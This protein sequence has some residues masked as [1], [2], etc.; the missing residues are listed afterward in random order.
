[1]VCGQNRRGAEIIDKLDT[2]SYVSHKTHVVPPL[3][4]PLFQPLV[5]A[6]L[7]APT[8][9]MMPGQ[10]Y[11][12]IFHRQH[13]LMHENSLYASNKPLRTYLLD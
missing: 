3:S 12:Q 1:M 6:A 8:G 4:P 10:N 5:A 9:H 13:P 11:A 7:V 2:N